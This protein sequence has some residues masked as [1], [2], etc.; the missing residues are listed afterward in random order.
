MN[1]QTSVIMAEVLQIPGMPLIDLIRF[2]SVPIIQTKRWQLSEEEGVFTSGN[3][4]FMTLICF[5]E[6]TNMK[7]LT[8]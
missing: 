6:S 7:I 4:V 5:D 1:K 2:Y 3:N 8:Q